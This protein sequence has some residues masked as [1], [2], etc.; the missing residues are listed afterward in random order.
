MNHYPPL[1]CTRCQKTQEHQELD[2]NRDAFYCPHSHGGVLAI[3]L[4]NR[5]WSVQTGVS[6]NDYR[7]MVRQSKTQTEWISARISG[8]QEP[9]N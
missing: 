8:S 2:V 6:P 4:P 3:R 5:H 1:V 7:R 9:L